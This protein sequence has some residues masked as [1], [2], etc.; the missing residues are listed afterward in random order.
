MAT[1]RFDAIVVG[2][3]AGGG[4]AAWAL[5]RAG[6]KVLLLEKGPHYTEKDFFH[7]EIAVC[8]R[9]FFVPDVFTEGNMIAA[10]GGAGGAGTAS[11]HR[12]G[13]GWIA[14]CVGGG[15]VHMSGFCFRLHPEDFQQ[16][17]RLGEVPGA[18]VAD[19]PFDYAAL[20]PYYDRVEEVLGVS[21]ESIRPRANPFETRTAPYPLRPI[22][23]HPAG[24]RIDQAC[25][26]LGMHPFVIP[27][28]ILSAPRGGRSACT[29]CG[30]CGSYGCEVG[31][32]SS[33]L[34]TFVAAALATGNL[35]LRARAAAVRVETDAHGRAAAVVYRDSRA[36][37][38]ATERR[39][40]A[41]AIVVAASAIQSARLLLASG[42][43]NG[44]G[45]LG[46]NLMFS[47]YSS[48]FARYRMPDPQFVSRGRDWPFLDRA[49]QDFYRRDEGPGGTILFLLPHVNPIYQAERAAVENGEAV[50]AWGAAL[51]RRLREMFHDTRTIEYETFAEFVPHA[52]CR[53][54]L[55]PDA[56]DPHGVPSARLEVA[57]HPRSLAASA[58]LGSRARA[59]LEA[60]SAARVAERPGEPAYLVLQAGTARM[61]VDPSRSVLSAAG[62]A[63]DVKNLFV[64]DGSGLPSAGAAPFTLTIMA[65]SLRIADGIVARGKRGEL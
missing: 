43:A 38:G 10:R 44:S 13:D 46:E 47:A 50:P 42:L 2:S 26:R 60:T 45:L 15:T 59:A 18:A 29:Y 17:T 1:D 28:A 48:G 53:V 35:E 49:V 40:R 24:E 41:R 64:T 14:C 27:R 51:V 57:V 25:T 11:A 55:D 32:K 21:G 37:G 16:R 12:S 61:G 54:R 23:T 33:T 65:N 3:G 4:P 6:W 58:F 36:P 7:D 63:H 19:W 5:A 34:A 62:E 20:E 56:K 31:A 22:A 39:A 52:G 9:S 30:F 8:R